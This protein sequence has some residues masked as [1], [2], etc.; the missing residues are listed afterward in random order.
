MALV[1][2]VKAEFRPDTLY[3]EK[4][5]PE[6]VVSVNRVD[7]SRDELPQQVLSL[8][9]SFIYREN[10][11]TIADALQASGQV[12][13]QKSQLGGGSP[14]LRGFE[15]SRILLVVDDV[16]MNNL[17]YRAGHLQ[18]VI[19]LDP[20]YLE[21]VETV[22]GP[23]STIYGSDA[24]GGVIHMRTRQPSFISVD[25]MQVKGAGL[26]RYSTAAHEKTSAFRVEF[27]RRNWA[28]LTAIGVSS[29][30]DL[31]MGKKAGSADT[32]WG[33]RPFFVERF[34]GNDSLVRNDDPYRQ[35]SSGYSQIDVLQRF[36]IR[37]GKNSVHGFNLQFSNSTDVPRYDRLTDPS[38][39][40]LKFAEW[41]YGPQKRFL[42]GYTFDR[43]LNGGFFQSMKSILSYQSV[44]ES[45]Y[46]RSFGSD[47]KTGRIERVKVIGFTF[48]FDR[49]NEVHE[50]RAGIDGQLSGVRSTASVENII[51]GVH[52][53]ASTRYPDGGNVMGNYAAFI[54]HSWKI[55]YK[56]DLSDGLRLTYTQLHSSF[57]DTT[58][59]P[60]PFTQVRQDNLALCGNI[61]F[62]FRPSDSWKF[63]LL[64]SSGFRSPN[65][66][67][68][69]KIFDSAPS[70]V[71]LPNPELGPERIW[72]LEAGFDFHYS[73]LTWET[74]VF[75]SLFDQ[76]IV[77]LPG[78]YDGKDSILY[79]GV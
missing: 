22:F 8:R 41:Y 49:E 14:V 7:Q 21:R 23:S 74:N 57:E 4:D 56:L 78:M 34:G 69:A 2:P 60:F 39:T 36:R 24:L 59:Y 29:F 30:D 1:Y 31:R 70:T 55:S 46:S 71:I 64:G 61:G 58:F 6:V 48:F 20:F 13:V 5:L 17:I 35:V 9:S 72:S 3:K 15:A 26:F 67:D 62:T 10:L 63:S 28:S 79:D 50:V 66:D 19:T 68:L 37:S 18:N 38:S 75:H 47:K 45:R 40:G 51:N 42:L 16:R 25:S 43:S 54:S 52:S 76:A 65:V 77:L 27:S 32:V 44:E 11:P 12:F 73:G 33:L 53:P